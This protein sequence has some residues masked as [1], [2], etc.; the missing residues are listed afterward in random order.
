[1][2]SNQA[3]WTRQVPAIFLRHIARMNQAGADDTYILVGLEHLKASAYD[4]CSG[5]RVGIEK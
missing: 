2:L 3:P 5:K 4:L 1:M